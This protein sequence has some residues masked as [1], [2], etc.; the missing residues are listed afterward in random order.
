LL[1]RKNKEKNPKSAHGINSIQNSKSIRTINDRQCLA[2]YKTL[3]L[4]VV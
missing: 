2:A 3:H 4:A 1:V